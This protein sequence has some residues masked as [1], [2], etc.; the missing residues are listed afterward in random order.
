MMLASRIN[1]LTCRCGHSGFLRMAENDSPFSKS[2]ENYSFEGFD[3]DSYYVD[4]W[5]H[6][7]GEIFAKT[8]PVCPKCGE[9]LTAESL[10]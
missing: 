4:G 8:K 1:P 2:F 3:A 6:D 5:V 7:K 9:I 10:K